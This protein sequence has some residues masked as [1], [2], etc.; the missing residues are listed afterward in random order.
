MGAL[1]I[2][3]EMISSMYMDLFKLALTHTALL[4]LL[5]EPDEPVSEVGSA[6]SSLKWLLF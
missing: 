5:C 2:S 1:C 3:N 4:Q 6:S